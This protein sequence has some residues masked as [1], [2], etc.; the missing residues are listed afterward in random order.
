MAESATVRG[1]AKLAPLP[2]ATLCFAS[3]RLNL[4]I[5]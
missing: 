5:R 4:R 1:D 2:D 3:L